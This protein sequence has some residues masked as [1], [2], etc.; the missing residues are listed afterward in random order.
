M[1]RLRPQHFFGVYTPK[2]ITGELEALRKQGDELALH[3]S[4]DGVSSRKALHEEKR[5]MENIWPVAI[6]G[7]RSHYLRFSE[8][9]PEFLIKEGFF[10]DSSMGF[11]FNNG[12][13]CGTAFPFVLHTS[14]NRLLWEIPL[15]IMDT[16]LMYRERNAN[17]GDGPEQI[18]LSLLDHIR[19]IH[20]MLV[21]NWH[22][23]HFNEKREADY[24]DLL[25]SMILRLKKE[26]AWVTTPGAL[27]RWWFRERP[28]R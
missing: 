16:A 10:Y 15:H 17:D 19:E 6:K 4:F 8:Q 9:T 11:N 3:I 7:A 24:F 20:G 14:G 12:F 2:E 13:R 21:V 25:Q 28:Q 27:L 1:L 18:F 5:Y 23:R 22:Q 26:A